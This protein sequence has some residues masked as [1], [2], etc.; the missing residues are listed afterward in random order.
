[1]SYLNS[2]T[3]P[4]AS[5]PHEVLAQIFSM[6]YARS[7]F[8][9]A[10]NPSLADFALVN[11]QWLEPARDILYIHVYL[12]TPDCLLETM[13]LFLCTLRSSPGLAG[14]VRAIGFGSFCMERGEMKNL[15]EAIKLCDNLQE[16]RLSGWNDDELQDL[17]DALLSKKRLQ[18]LHVDRHALSGI[19]C[20]SV[21]QVAALRLAERVLG[22]APSRGIVPDRAA[23]SDLW[24][25]DGLMMRRQ[26]LLVPLQLLA[27]RL[28]SLVLNL[29]ER[30]LP[31]V[32]RPMDDIISAMPLLRALYVSSFYLKP[33]TLSHGFSDL[34]ILDYRVVPQELEEFIT[35]LSNPSTLPAL[36]EVTLILRVSYGDNESEDE[37][38]QGDVENFDT[39]M[40]EALR[41]LC[42]KRGIK[43]RDQFYRYMQ[44]LG[45]VY[46]LDGS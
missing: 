9:R 11:K 3:S 34:K 4:A 16:L 29:Q 5:A 27:P 22:G 20:G 23:L 28:T 37:S 43:I 18:V 44:G 38:S 15:A 46:D 40:F 33:A 24:L 45:I 41:A 13:E 42:L 6:T 32:A 26:Q 1:M 8:D 21:S 39:D 31:T 25:N 17:F 30:W 36:R 7:A 14:L 2:G 12:G 35:I 10:A 19:R